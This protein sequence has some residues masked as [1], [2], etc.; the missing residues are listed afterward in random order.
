MA[1]HSPL[2]SILNIQPLEEREK[3]ISLSYKC[4]ITDERIVTVPAWIIFLILVQFTED[5]ELEF[6]KSVSQ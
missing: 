6:W 4:Q 3:K 5:A 2:A 1:T